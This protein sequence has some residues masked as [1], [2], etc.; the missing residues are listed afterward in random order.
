MISF[1]GRPVIRALV[2]FAAI[3]PMPVLP[4]EAFQK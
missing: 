2:L 4:P 1:A 3:V